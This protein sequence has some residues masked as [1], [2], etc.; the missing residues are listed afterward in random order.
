MRDRVA[1]RWDEAQTEILRQFANLGAEAVA[2][3]IAQRTGAIHTPA[4][5][6]RKAS[7]MG[8]SLA[9]AE[10]CPGCGRRM[11]R[12]DRETGLCP[13]CKIKFQAERQKRFNAQLDAEITA[14]KQ[15]KEYRDAIKDYQAARQETSRKTRKYGLPNMRQRRKEGGG[16][17]V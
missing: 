7:R 6:Q 11:R 14:I 2:E 3:I 9:L 15:E 13:V 8:V 16:E 4:S 17:C 5:V 12:L 1:V 10:V